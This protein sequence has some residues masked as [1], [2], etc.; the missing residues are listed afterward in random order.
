MKLKTEMLKF[1]IF[2]LSF[3]TNPNDKRDV[4]KAHNVIKNL[5]NKFKGVILT[6]PERKVKL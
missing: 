1:E 3:F 4:I 2:L 6:E 5:K